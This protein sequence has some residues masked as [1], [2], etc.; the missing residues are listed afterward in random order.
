LVFFCIIPALFLSSLRRLPT[1][2]HPGAPG[3]PGAPGSQGKRG[4]IG[5]R[6]FP[7]TNGRPGHDG[8]NG[9][10]GLP[11]QAGQRGEKG[12]DGS[13]GKASGV[14]AAALQEFYGQLLGVVR[15]ASGASD[16][17]GATVKLLADKKVCIPLLQAA[18]TV[19][20]LRLVRLCASLIRLARYCAP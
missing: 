5:L 2:C 16:V 3:T 8:A 17:S 18:N 7:G 20:F 9:H 6:G 14:S 1:P 4:D 13:P 15:R 11:G 10:N 12:S 19:S